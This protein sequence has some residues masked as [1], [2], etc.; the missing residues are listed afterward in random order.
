MLLNQTVV[1]RFTDTVEFRIFMAVFSSRF[2]GGE[3]GE[4]KLNVE[5]RLNNSA[6]RQMRRHEKSISFV[7]LLGWTISSSEMYIG[8]L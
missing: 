1:N 6:Y 8:W 7:K 2:D 4:K 3:P 5:S